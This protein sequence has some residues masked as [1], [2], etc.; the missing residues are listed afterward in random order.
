[1][2]S[3]AGAPAPSR[4]SPLPFAGSTTGAGGEQGPY[5]PAPGVTR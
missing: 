1:M 2:S 5:A 3:I 4:S